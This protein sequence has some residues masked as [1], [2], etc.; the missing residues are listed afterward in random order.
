M[1]VGKAQRAHQFT[2]CGGHGASAPL[3]TLRKLNFLYL[4]EVECTRKTQ[5]SCP[6]LIRASIYLCKIF[7]KKMD[8]RVKPGDDDLNWC[9]SETIPARRRWADRRAAGAGM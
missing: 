7:S 6:D 9:D 2:S 8:H 4:G 1:R 3:P 5:S